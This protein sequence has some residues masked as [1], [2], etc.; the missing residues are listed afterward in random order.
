M[1]IV[2][3]DK[4]EIE[5]RAEKSDSAKH[6]LQQ[7]AWLVRF[8]NEHR[9]IKVNG[10]GLSY[11]FEKLINPFHKKDPYVKHRC[12]KDYPWVCPFLQAGTHVPCISRKASDKRLL[13]SIELTN[14][15]GKEGFQREGQQLT[16]FHKG[17]WKQK[18]TGEERWTNEPRPYI[19]ADIVC[20]DMAVASME[21]LKRQCFDALKWRI[22]PLTET[23]SDMDWIN[24]QQVKYSGRFSACVFD[25]YD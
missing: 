3:P 19:L 23:A 21:W 17:Y 22:L 16:L 6:G 2:L 12:I 24:R 7:E 11:Y 13:A 1:I 10:A 14:W 15:E 9:F 8:P 25:V 5:I 18:N 4:N 20:K